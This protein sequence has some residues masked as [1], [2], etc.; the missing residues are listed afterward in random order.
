MKPYAHNAKMVGFVLE[1][2]LDVI[3]FDGVTI[4][5]YD[6]ILSHGEILWKEQACSK[7]I[8]G[9]VA[10][11]DSGTRLIGYVKLYS[12]NFKDK[13]ANEYLI[14]LWVKESHVALFERH[15]Q[16]LSG[17][18]QIEHVFEVEYGFPIAEV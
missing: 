3:S 11:T 8:I 6:E 2:E 15:F 16:G 1:G 5:N 17:N 10:D 13:F 4:E 7:Y 14:S 12:D 9:V 18:D